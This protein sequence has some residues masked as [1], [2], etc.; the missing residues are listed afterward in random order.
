MRTTRAISSLGVA[1]VLLAWAVWQFS[2]GG[3]SSD[4][5]LLLAQDEPPP[6]A[7]CVPPLTPPPP[8]LY[9]ILRLERVEFTFSEIKGICVGE[10]SQREIEA[11]VRNVG[12]GFASAFT[13]RVQG[14]VERRVDIL[15]P[16]LD[17]FSDTSC[18]TALAE[19]RMDSDEP[20]EILVDA[21]CET[22]L[23]DRD[24]L[25]E[26]IRL[27]VPEPPPMCTPGPSPSAS[28]SATA[29]EDAT[30]TPSR[31]AEPSVTPEPTPTATL[32]PAPLYAPHALA[33]AMLVESVSP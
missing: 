26:F 31:T 28:P 22:G 32:V 11:C 15:M 9:P 24:G 30:S 3:A 17:A 8:G 7:T 25:H 10:G 20:C 6:I 1:T 18:R 4:T 12:P 5:P 14:C 16:E 29:T 2:D 19:P 27:S 33:N 13:V 21:E 23:F